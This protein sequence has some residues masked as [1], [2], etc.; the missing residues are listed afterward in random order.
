MTA[1]FRAPSELSKRVVSRSTHI[2]RQ[3][4]GP[5]VGQD[6]PRAADVDPFPAKHVHPPEGPAEHRESCI[7]PEEADLVTLAVLRC[8]WDALESVIRRCWR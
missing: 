5:A 2:F 6:G 8:W 1:V 4:V 7:V 3:R